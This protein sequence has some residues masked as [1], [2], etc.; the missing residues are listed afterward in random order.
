MTGTQKLLVFF[1]FCFIGCTIISGFMDMGSGLAATTLTAN[2][3][4]TDVVLTV[5]NTDDFFDSPGATVDTIFIGNEE[6]GY[7]GK[8]PLTFTGCVRGSGAKA[9]VTGSYVY[10][11]NTNLLNAIVGFNVAQSTSTV[12]T[13]RAY[14]SVST[15]MMKSI[16]KFIAWDYSFFHGDLVILQF[17]MFAMSAGMIIALAA[18][19]LQ[20][21]SGLFL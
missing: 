18:M 4:A 9:H 10:A 19:A 1:V 7:T 12:G 14:W 15:A 3:L 8:T 20:A 11:K 21:I 16:P 5:G 2:A 6:I 13:F 17:F